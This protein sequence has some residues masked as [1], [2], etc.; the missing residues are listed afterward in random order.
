VMYRGLVAS[1][2]DCHSICT[3]IATTYRVEGREHGS[4]PDISYVTGSLT[5][6][7]LKPTALDKPLVLRAK[8]TEL[9]E[10]KA[11]VACDVYSGDEKTAEGTV[12]AVRFH[13]DKSLGAPIGR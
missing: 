3:A 4:H 11:V 8:V 1:L 2:M 6:S 10:R 13:M 5:I 7:Y 12:L 9:R